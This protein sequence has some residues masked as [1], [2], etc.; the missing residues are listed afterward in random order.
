MLTVTLKQASI[1]HYIKEITTEVN[2][3]PTFK[4]KHV[5]LILLSFI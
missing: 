2:N 5:T 4:F 3:N 1:E